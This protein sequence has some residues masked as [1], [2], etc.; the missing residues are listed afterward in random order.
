MQR[1]TCEG[2]CFNK[3]RYFF[4]SCFVV[5]LSC[6]DIPQIGLFPKDVVFLSYTGLCVMVVLLWV[7]WFSP[8]SFLVWKKTGQTLFEPRHGPHGRQLWPP[9]G[10]SV[11]VSHHLKPVIWLGV[12]TISPFSS[13]L[14]YFNTFV[15][16]KFGLSTNYAP[17]SQMKIIT[18]TSSCCKHRCLPLWL[19]IHCILSHISAPHTCASAGLSSMC[20]LA[21]TPCFVAVEL[22]LLFPSFLLTLHSPTFVTRMYKIY[23]ILYSW[24][25]TVTFSPWQL[26]L[27]LFVSFASNTNGAVKI[28]ILRVSVCKTCLIQCSTTWILFTIFA[29]CSCHKDIWKLNQTS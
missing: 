11:K 28:M 5:S 17:S 26:D 3:Y 8:N 14:F 25:I 1:D 22:S 21:N 2:K 23:S 12:K 4:G 6:A 27:V 13:L 15:K 29:T 10:R 16:A 24:V 19:W 18:K 7:G 20:F 9:G